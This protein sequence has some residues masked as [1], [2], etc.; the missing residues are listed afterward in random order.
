MEFYHCGFHRKSY[1]YQMIILLP[2]HWMGF[3]KGIAE[4]FS[5]DYDVCFL[6]L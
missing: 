4:L 6:H 5:L 2:D 3:K 1:L